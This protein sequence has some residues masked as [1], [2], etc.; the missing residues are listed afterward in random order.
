MTDLMRINFRGDFAW[1]PLKTGKYFNL[2]KRNPVASGDM[3][4]N[5]EAFNYAIVSKENSM[6]ES[7]SN[8]LWAILSNYNTM[9]RHIDEL[10]SGKTITELGQ[11]GIEAFMNQL[12]VGPGDD[13]EDQGG[14][15]Y[16]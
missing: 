4:V 2:C 11:G 9:E 14:H 3:L 5:G 13:P 6:V 12:K 16:H 7:M 1:M 15:G 8:Q 10:L